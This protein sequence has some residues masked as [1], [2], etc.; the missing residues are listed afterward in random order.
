MNDTIKLISLV[1]LNYPNQVIKMLNENAVVVDATNFTT[2]ELSDATLSGL[3]T[4]KKFNNDFISFVKS[5]SINNS[6]SNADAAST[7]SSFGAN[8][9]GI[10]SSGIG[11]L[12]TLFMSNTNTKNLQAQLDA[13]NN[14]NLTDLQLAD[15]QI[16]LAKIGLLASQNQLSGASAKKG[17]NTTL[18][19]ALGIGGALILGLTIFL[20][21]RNKN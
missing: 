7:G 5:L 20:V 19:I 10:I 15:K 1:I 12:T 21:T 8:Y 9:G 2:K 17:G 3:T 18:Y 13:Q 16:E 4:S 11:S 6:Y 14:K